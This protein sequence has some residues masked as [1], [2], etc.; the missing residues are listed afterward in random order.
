MRHSVRMEKGILYTAAVLLCL[1]LVSFWMM[2]NILARYATTASGSDSA[3]V[4]K[5]EIT[6]KMLDSSSQEIT[7]FAVDMAPGES[8][9]YTI[10][11]TNSSEVSVSYE[12]SGESQYHNLPLKCEMLDKDGNTITSDEIP[13]ND[14][15]THRYQFKVSWPTDSADNRN[16]K[17]M[18]KT[19]V[20]LVSLKAVQID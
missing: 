10:Q 17:Y 9:T 3:R 14:S 5:F 18:G 15:S 16:E 1:V 20:V 4:A 8:Q 2:S 19:D 13:V 6:D 12:I 11:V 7:T